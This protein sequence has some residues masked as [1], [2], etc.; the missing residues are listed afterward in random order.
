MYVLIT[1]VTVVLFYLGKNFFKFLFRQ[2][3]NRIF[4]FYIYF[5][6]ALS[7]HVTPVCR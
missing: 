6:C 7:V 1:V 4:T 3:F 5:V 2:D